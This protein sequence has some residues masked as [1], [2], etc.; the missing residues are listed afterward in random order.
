MR[1]QEYPFGLP[2]MTLRELVQC[3]NGGSLF[4]R[5]LTILLYIHA[6]G[7]ATTLE[8]PKGPQDESEHLAWSIWMS[9]MIQRILLDGQMQMITFMQGPLGRPFWKPTRLLAGRLEGLAGDLY[10]QYQPNWRPSM[11]L[12]GKHSDGSWRTM[13]AKEYPP[14]LCEILA[15]AYIKHSASVPTEG[16]EQTPSNVEQS[17]QVLTAALEESGEGQMHSDFQFRNFL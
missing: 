13:A 9:S 17:L 8:H 4:L 7:G 10:R 2:G 12:G 11:W 6:F 1:T 16:T 14:K 3:V 5:V 15:H